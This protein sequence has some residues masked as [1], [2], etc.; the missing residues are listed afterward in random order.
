MV[1]LSALTFFF[2]QVAYSRAVVIITYSFAFVFFSFWRTIFKV[3]FKIGLETDIRKSRT[4][5][6]ANEIKAEELAVKLKSTFTRLYHVVGLIGL[7]RKNVGSQVGNYKILGAVDNIKK[8]IADEKINKVI[9]SSDDLSFNQMFAIVSECY[10]EN[11]EFLVAGKELNYLV[12]KSSITMLDDI[13]LLRVQY[14]IS[15]YL[16]RAIKRT[17]DFVLGILI[18]FLVYPFIYL[19]H[20]FTSKKNEFFR[21]ILGIPKIVTGEKSFVGPKNSS[22]SGELYVGKIGLTGFWFIESSLESDSEES[23]KMEIFYAKNQNIWLDLEILGKSFSK[24][25]F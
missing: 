24:M 12:G 5:I 21:F 2:K 14:N 22:F 13:P 20:K 18:L 15:S 7:T 11:A 17:F 8:I 16:H 6:I 10:G 23:R 4:L 9:F 3:I 19:I 1:F 25:F